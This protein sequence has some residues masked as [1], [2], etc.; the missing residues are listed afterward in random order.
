MAALSDRTPELVIQEVAGWPFSQFKNRLTEIAVATLGP[1]TAEMNRLMA[2]PAEI[3]RALKV[4]AEKARAL[5]APVLK[6]AYAAVG[7]L[8]AA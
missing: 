5:A 2:D 7:F 1:I 3:D 8:P 4:G 6:E